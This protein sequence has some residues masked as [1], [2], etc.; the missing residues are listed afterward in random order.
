MTANTGIVG[1]QIP[2]CAL[3]LE[4][5]QKV[6][7]HL[8]VNGG[9]F[10]DLRGLKKEHVEAM[11]SMGHSFYEAGNYSEAEPV[12]RV[13]C[14]FDHLD[15]KYWLAFGATL[16][17]GNKHSQAIAAYSYAVLLD[18]HDPRAPF[19]AAECHMSLG[20]KTAAICAL[21]TAIDFAGT[22]PAYAEIS[23]KA[24]TLL[25]ILESEHPDA[26]VGK[27]VSK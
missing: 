9:V 18:I 27:N 15:K 25:K 24:K 4:E 23:D 20:N 2:G 22:N 7:K 6:V 3:S 26:D 1:T 12:F 10:R 14:F 8:L 19:H 5:I 13:L 16:Q 11:Y 21:K 17:M